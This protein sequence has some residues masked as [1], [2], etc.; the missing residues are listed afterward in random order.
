MILPLNNL[1]I[2]F[3]THLYYLIGNVKQLSTEKVDRKT[4]LYV[5]ALV[6]IVVVIGVVF[7]AWALGQAICWKTTGK[8]FVFSTKLKTGTFKLGCR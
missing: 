7:V 8:D 6:F 4:K 5:G 3:Y 2:Q 1:L